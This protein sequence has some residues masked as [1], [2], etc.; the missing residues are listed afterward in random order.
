M[1]YA[2]V[3]TSGFWLLLEAEGTTYPYHTDEVEQ[4]ILCQ[5]DISDPNAPR[6]LIPIDPGNI[7]DGEPW[8]PVD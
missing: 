2:T 5:I 7:K 4:V 8:M 6:P 3:T 1:A